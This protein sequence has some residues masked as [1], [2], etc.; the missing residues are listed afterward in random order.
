MEIAELKRFTD[1]FVPITCVISVEKYPDGDYGNIR[2]VTGNEAYIHSQDNPLIAET[3]GLHHNTF[4]PDQPYERYIPKDLNFEDSVYHCAI[5]KQPYHAYVQPD[6]FDFWLNITMMPLESDDPNIGYCTY[7]QTLTKEGDAKERSNLSYEASSDVLRTCIK[8]RGT[9][10]YQ[11]SMDE[12]IRD[13]GELCGSSHCVVLLM[14]F[15]TRTCSV[16]SENLASDSH[17]KSIKA[18][19]DDGFFEIAESWEETIAGSSYLIIENQHDMEVVRERNPRWH[20]S[21]VDANVKSLVLFPLKYGGVLLGYIW[22][23]NFDTQ[24]TYR[25]RETLDLTTFFLASEIANHKMVDQ[26]RVMSSIDMLT[27][28][29]NRNAMNNRV[30]ELDR[31][32]SGEQGRLAV[33][34]AD[35]NGLKHVNDYEGHRA[36]DLLLKNAALLLQRVFIGSEIYRAGGDEF[37]IFAIDVSPEELADQI[38]LLRE[39]GEAAGVSFAL[40]CAFAESAEEVRPA[41]RI[42][43]ERMYEDKARYYEMHPENRRG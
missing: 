33:V 24:N 27:G 18:Y 25:I 6:R 28:V 15:T 17:L 8:L 14:D 34:F 31:V 36:G 16:L 20:K 2:I 41:M 3:D 12:V 4:E 21:L 26:L 7:S 40:G 1:R 39:L 43:D 23:T 10:D 42:A 22:V 37:V 35:L 9:T 32:Y 13:I 5:L 11:K 38:E 29:S 30:I 19:L